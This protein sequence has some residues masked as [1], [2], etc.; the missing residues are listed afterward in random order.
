MKLFGLHGHLQNSKLF[1]GKIGGLLHQFKKI[2]VEIIFIDS[3]YVCP[4][5]TEDPPLRTWAQN[6]S[7]KEAEDSI[8]AAKEA[9][10]EV[11]GFFCFSMGS[12]L[13]LHLAAH[14]ATHQDSPFSWIK[15]IVAVS[16]PYPKPD[17]PLLDS[18]PCKCEI[19]VLFVIGKSDE[20]ALPD[21]QRKYLD[22][23]PNATVFE[24]D[25][26]HYVPGARQYVQTYVDFFT[27]CK[28]QI[29]E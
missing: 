4:E 15:L 1:K 12:M 24:H 23:F 29:E 18:L 16:A 10:P 28:E 6:N 7:I 22:S 21:S 11:C 2:G 26:G 25:G 5:S 17:S 8:I 3:P 20:I 14:A 13:A 9:H 19:P 27:K